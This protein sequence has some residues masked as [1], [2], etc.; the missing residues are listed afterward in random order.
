MSDELRIK[1]ILD[2]GS[3]KEGFVSAEKQ[4]EKS[5]KKIGKSFDEKGSGL[6]S[7]ADGA[8]DAAGGFSNTSDQCTN[9]TSRT[10]SSLSH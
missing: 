1:I 9:R 3:V 7:L 8:D 10:N 6:Q 2:D 4:A 5:A